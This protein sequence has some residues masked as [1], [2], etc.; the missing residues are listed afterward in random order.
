MRRFEMLP[1][2]KQCCG[3]GSGKYMSRI[4]GKIYVGYETGFGSGSETN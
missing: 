1:L 3:F 4:L 2:Q